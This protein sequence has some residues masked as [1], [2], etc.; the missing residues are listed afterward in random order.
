MKF[1]II[2][3]CRD[4]FELTKNCI[5]SIKKNSWHFDIILIDSGSSEET[6]KQYQ[7][8]MF[9]QLKLISIPEPLSFAR[10][11][12]RGLQMAEGEFWI[13]LNNDVIIPGR[14]LI[15]LEDAYNKYGG[16]I[17]VAGAD[18]DLN[19]GIAKH[20]N[21]FWW[22]EPRNLPKQ[23]D[24]CGMQCLY[25]HS[26]VFKDIG[27]LDENFEFG[28]WE[29]AD[30]GIRALMR[31]YTNTVIGL[32][33]FEHLGQATAKKVIGNRMIE[34]VT[35]NGRYLAQKWAHLASSIPISHLINIK[36]ELKNV[37]KVS[38]MTLSWETKDA[39]IKC[40]EAILREIEILEGLGISIKLIS[41]DNGSKDGTAEYLKTINRIDKLILNPENLGISKGR[42]QAIDERE[43]RYL[44]MVDGDISIVKGSFIAMLRYM[45]QHPEISNLGAWSHR[46]TKNWNEQTKEIWELK[47]INEGW[48]SH[49]NFRTAMTQYGLWRTE[50]FEIIRFDE[51]GAFGEP[52]WGWEDNLAGSTMVLKGFRIQRFD[53]V[54]YYHPDIMSS[55]HKLAKM[56]L[57]RM[58]DRIK[59]LQKRWD[60]ILKEHGQN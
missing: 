46:I 42:N 18:L 4:N 40:I 32:P 8:I 47:K 53:D 45:E 31:G 19:G 20:K 17:G 38:I 22:K 54:V 48:C 49:A 29:D 52:G 41:V 14:W 21:L 15:H 55:E 3:P 1:S 59:Y 12:N 11:I 24:Y 44:F 10:A 2:L 50:I 39:T 16:L 25:S 56:G 33:N 34:I 37:G 13:I 26:S 43:G 36:K 35:K 57:S 9:D 6:K 60:E 28:Y 5:E 58:D 51:G 23:V 7:N 27:L 30:Y